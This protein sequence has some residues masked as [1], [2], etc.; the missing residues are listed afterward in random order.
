MDEKKKNDNIDFVVGIYILK[1]IG[2]YVEENDVIAEIHSESKESAKAI[3]DRI[4]ASY[5]FSTEKI[6]RGSVII[7]TIV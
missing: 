3:E 1:K 5:E 7:D 4:L 6:E 2:D